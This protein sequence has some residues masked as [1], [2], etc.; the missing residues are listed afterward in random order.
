MQELHGQL[1]LL[2][3]IFQS[4]LRQRRSTKCRGRFKAGKPGCCILP[5]LWLL[6]LL[7]KKKRLDEKNRQIQL[8]K[9]SD[10]VCTT[11]HTYVVDTVVKLKLICLPM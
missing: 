2:T 4:R 10:V 9:W 8:P 1:G 11:T 5:S 3:V 7:K 6:D